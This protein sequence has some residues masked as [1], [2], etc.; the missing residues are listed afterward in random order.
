[1]IPTDAQALPQASFGLSPASVPVISISCTGA[2]N[3]LLDCI[4]TNTTCSLGGG[5]AVECP[6]RCSIEGEVRL[7]GGKSEMEGQVEICQ[8]SSW[9]GICDSNWC[10]SNA[11][12]VCRQLGYS[13]FSKRM[14]FYMQ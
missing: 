3:G 14:L 11:K 9:G 1:M 8:N 6:E 10:G 12:V 13:E 7:T 5:A 4:L 2:E